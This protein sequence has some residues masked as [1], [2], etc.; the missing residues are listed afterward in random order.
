MMTNLPIT[1]VLEMKNIKKTF[2][3]TPALT[4]VE[5][6]IYPGE[7]HALMGEN[8]AGKS[9]LMKIL[10][11]AY[12]ADPGAEIKINGEPVE[13][14]T[15]LA[16]KRLGIAVIYQELSLSPN[17]TVAEN[18]FLGVE[19]NSFGIIDRKKMERDA[20]PLL[21]RLGV[22][23]KPDTLVAD[24]SLAEQQLT[25]IARAIQAD[26]HILIMDEPTT[27]L[28]SRE[29]DR[30]FHLMKELRRQQMAIIY[31]S[32]RMNEIDELADR[33]SVIRDGGYVGSLSREMLSSEMLIKMMV[34]RNMSGFYAKER[35]KHADFGPVLLDINEISDGQFIKPASLAIRAGEVVGL[36]GLVG[37]GRTELARLIVG[38]DRITRGT[39]NLAGK[40]VVIKS[41]RQA[42][43]NGIAYLT[44][45]RKSQGLFLDMSV[46]DNIN[47]AVIGRD[48][49]AG[50][51]NVKKV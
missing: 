36:S 47:L 38:A 37:S 44:E 5:L 1:P 19:P 30:L 2:F 10:S 4:G 41:P 14:G 20:T 28:T 43:A 27:S 51:L 33:V 21:D 34:G 50:V 40:P 16:A 3:N 35:G 9:T 15:P 49:W 11:G 26:A 48:S 18:I 39:V 6:T 45:D 29:T 46:R 23:F 22:T 8:G 7:I 25:E 17:L 13:I 32:H 31:I 24:L 42:I 12:Q